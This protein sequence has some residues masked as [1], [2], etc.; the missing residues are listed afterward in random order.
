MLHYYALRCTAEKKAMAAGKE[1][2]AAIRTKATKATSKPCPEN[3]EGMLRSFF[4]KEKAQAA[5]QVPEQG[6]ESWLRSCLGAADTAKEASS[7]MQADTQKIR[8]VERSKKLPSGPT[9]TIID[10][11]PASR[12]N[13]DR[14]FSQ[15]LALWESLPRGHAEVRGETGGLLCELAAMRKFGSSEEKFGPLAREANG[16]RRCAL[17]VLPAALRSMD[18]AQ[19]SLSLAVVFTT[20]APKL[21]PKLFLLLLLSL[22][23]LVSIVIVIVII[24]EK[25]FFL[26][27]FCCFFFFFLG[28]WGIC[29]AGFLG[30]GGEWGD[31]QG[32]LLLSRPGPGKATAQQQ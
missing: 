1:Q 3:S 22:L 6:V 14:A 24:A 31:V 4:G 23:S 10:S 18:E 9:F 27:F 7:S 32:L 25:K 19:H 2:H 12:A 30:L 21:Q 20:K 26:L 16:A 28:P 11:Q 13:A 15:N 8:K 29:G 17:S 5:P